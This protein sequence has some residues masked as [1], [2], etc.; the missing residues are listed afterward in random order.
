MSKYAE[1]CAIVIGVVAILLLPGCVPTTFERETA[2]V[3]AALDAAMQRAILC[4]QFPE[5][6]YCGR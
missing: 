6:I 1:Y 3:N 2:G 5:S 4:M